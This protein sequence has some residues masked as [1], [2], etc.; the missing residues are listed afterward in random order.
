MPSTRR[1]KFKTRED[2]T[3]MSERAPVKSYMIWSGLEEGNDLLGPASF[4]LLYIN[5]NFKTHPIRGGA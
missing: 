1:D 3:F 5:N 4:N 2:V